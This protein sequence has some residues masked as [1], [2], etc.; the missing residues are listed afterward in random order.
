VKPAHLHLTRTAL[1]TTASLLAIAFTS[2]GCATRGHLR[3]QTASDSIA[4]GANQIDNARR[5][6]AETTTGLRTLVTQPEVD[7]RAAY[8]RFRN[9]VAALERSV[10]AVNAEAENIQ[11]QGQRYFEHWNAQVA[12]M[13][14]EDIRARSVSRQ[15][16]VSRQFAQLQQ[17]YQ[18]ARQEFVPLMT[19]LRDIQRLIS[20]DLTPAGIAGAREFA[21]RAEQDAARVQQTLDRLAETFRQMSGV[22]SFPDARST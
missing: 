16:E 1:A 15:E 12:E 6:L 9:A 13:R 18:Q 3:A 19:T 21:A 14:N 17:Q 2:T 20:A 4:T 5:H 8:E 22:L 11:W 10:A 7:R